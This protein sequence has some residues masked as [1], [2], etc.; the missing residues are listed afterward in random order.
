[1]SDY[2]SSC[3]LGEALRHQRTWLLL[4]PGGWVRMP[5]RRRGLV[6]GGR[7]PLEHLPPLLLL[8]S[9][10]IA[11]RCVRAR[12]RPGQLTPEP[13]RFSNDST[14]AVVSRYLS[15]HRQ[16]VTRGGGRRSSGSY[17]WR[18]WPRWLP[19]RR[20]KA[21]T[22]GSPGCS[23]SL[24]S[25]AGRRTQLHGKTFF[26][27]EEGGRPGGSIPQAA[28][29]QVGNAE[30][31]SVAELLPEAAPG[32]QEENGETEKVTWPAASDASIP[33]DVGVPDTK[34]HPLSNPCPFS[35]LSN[36]CPGELD[37]TCRRLSHEIHKHVSS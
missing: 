10:R 14:R 16:G 37:L 28:V 26:C 33:A 2:R 34:R 32:L 7:R 11:D 21:S 12:D 22:R 18:P 6:V 35:I 8:P 15:P 5:G 31:G 19:S 1:M 20:R 9:P 30:S 36:K 3:H 13:A 4:D 17:R 23:F 29:G 25:L 27:L 24:F